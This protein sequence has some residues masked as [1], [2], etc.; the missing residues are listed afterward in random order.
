V[1]AARSLALVLVTV[2]VLA[3]VVAIG[4]GF[5]DGALVWLGLAALGAAVLGLAHALA[6]RRPRLGSLRR[7]F[8]VGV[9]IAVGQLVVLAAVAAQLMFVS[10]HD[11]LLLMVIVVFAG[12]VAVR[13]A[14]LFANN[15]MHDVEALRDTL[16]AV[17][18]GSRT[19][20]AVTGSA[21]ELAELARAA[22]TAIA[23]LDRAEIARR[24]LIAA[25]SHDLRT[26]ITSLRLLTEAVGDDIVD[27][28]TRRGYLGQMGTHIDVLAALIDDLFELS[29][30][31][32]G[33]IQWTLQQVPLGQLVEE[34]VDA[35]RPDAE[36][37]GVSVRADVR[38]HQ[39]AR[40]NPEKVQRVLFNLIQNAIRHTPADGSV[41]VLAEAADGRV[42]IEVADTG[43]G[44]G[45][46]DRGR[47]FE[48]FYRGGSDAARTRAGAGLGLAISRAIVEAH[49]G[50]IWLADSPTGTRVRFS[51]PRS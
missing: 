18:E 28:P 11:A 38:A 33:D 31:E 37:K 2:T 34:A 24:D 44:I 15:A 45:E 30:L 17:G 8:A 42:E 51:L 20:A 4:Y 48:P 14:Q 5:G 32:A 35:L 16:V 50:R 22:N 7:Q 19:P 27:A 36:A 41:T 49:G 40:A 26:P 47:V 12:V 6:R 13:A 21:D 43:D 1:S 3:A 23:K 9:A 10:A 39:P 46:N 25:V 29:R